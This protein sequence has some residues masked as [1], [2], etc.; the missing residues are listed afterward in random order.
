MMENWSPFQVLRVYVGEYKIADYFVE[1]CSFVADLT[2][3]SS[4]EAVSPLG[5]IPD[6][7]VLFNFFSS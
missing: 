2:H 7:D 3:N 5:F 4:G 6:C 1:N